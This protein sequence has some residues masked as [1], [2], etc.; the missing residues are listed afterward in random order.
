M[1]SNPFAGTRLGG[2]GSVASAAPPL[3]GTADVGSFDPSDPFSDVHRSPSQSS[4]QSIFSADDPFADVHARQ[5]SN[6]HLQ[7][8]Y[9][10]QSTVA[11][12]FGGTRL[13]GGRQQQGHS[14]FGQSFVPPPEPVPQPTSIRGNPKKK[15]ESLDLFRP[16]ENDEYAFTAQGHFMDSI[17]VDDSSSPRDR[18]SMSPLADGINPT[19]P[20][21]VLASKREMNL[22]TQVSS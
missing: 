18:N 16:P 9:P 6:S 19:D 11:N 20:I 8:Q 15:R 4:S 1:S 13:G 10:T 14:T 21:V 17:I 12:P 5:Q 2:R 7:G 3:G 22:I